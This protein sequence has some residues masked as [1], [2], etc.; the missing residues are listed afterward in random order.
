MS[1]ATRGTTG[2]RGGRRA[3]SAWVLVVLGG[4]IAV[5][6][7]LGG[8][9]DLALE[10]AVFY[11][12]AAAVVW[13]WAGRRGDVAAILGGAGDERQRAIDLRATALSG[14]A[15]GLFSLAAGIVSLAR[16]GDAGAW[17]TL[18][19]VGG[20]AYAVALVVLRARS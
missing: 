8:Q 17:G 9:Q 18:C 3:G 4:A 15:M 1:S 19:L 5:A 20:L 7:W 2:T 16:T 6:A 13:H 10:L 14:L 11:V 12:G